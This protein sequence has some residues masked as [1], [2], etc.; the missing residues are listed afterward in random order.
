[1]QAKLAAQAGLQTGGCGGVGR[2][3]GFIML[4]TPQKKATLRWLLKFLIKE[5][6]VGRSD[7]WFADVLVF[8]F[9]VL[10]FPNPRLL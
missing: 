2:A 8:Y 10:V 6:V 9:L 7:K 1:L 3:H 5:D 4:K